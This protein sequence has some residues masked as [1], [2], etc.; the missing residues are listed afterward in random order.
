MCSKWVGMGEECPKNPICP[1]SFR[2]YIRR[3]TARR[4][5]TMSTGALATALRHTRNLAGARPAGGLTDRQLLEHFAGQ[6][7]EAAFAALVERHGPMVLGVCRRLL[8]NLHDAEDAFQATF[9]VLARRAGSIHRRESLGG[10]LYVVAYRAAIKT[11]AQAARR[12]QAT[13]PTE[14]VGADPLAEVSG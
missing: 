1:S 12:Q 2:H 4:T 7:E 14:R 5:G 11:R 13:P 9:L 10:W 3:Q 6:G 8:G